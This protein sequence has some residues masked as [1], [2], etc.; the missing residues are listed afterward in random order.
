MDIQKRFDRIVAIFLQLQSKSLVKAQDL[1]DKFEVSL[2]TI[3]RDIRSLEKAGVPIYSEAGIGYSLMNSYKL[4]PTLFTKDEALSFVTAEKL[5][6]TFLDKKLASDFSTA[7]QK[8][9]AVLRTPEKQLVDYADKNVILHR[10]GK[11]KY[12]NTEIPD[13]LNILLKS[14]S[15]HKQITIQYR[16]PN[17]HAVEKRQLEPVGLFLN[18]G[19]WYFMA[20]CHLRKD[21]RQFRLDRVQEIVLLEDDFE[22]KHKELSHYL[23]KEKAPVTTF[24]IQI[25]IDKTYASY[26][27]W[28]RDYFGFKQELDNG[29]SLI[30]HFD[31]PEKTRQGFVRWFIMFGDHATIIEPSSLNEDVKTLLLKQLQ[32]LEKTKSLSS[33]T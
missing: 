27:G 1:A 21:Y 26:L 3:Y 12:F 14:I 9:K 2:R 23:K 30:M 4:P 29:D 17:S 19:Y 5:M 6:N 15:S 10:K 22:L 13:A 24:P 18:T 20:Y 31:C 25:Q 11:D 8:M 32:H 16:K 7:L 28:E 33:P